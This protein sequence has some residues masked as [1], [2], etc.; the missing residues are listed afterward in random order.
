MI[1]QR[2]GK[3]TAEK[4]KPR[5]CH[6]AAGAGNMCKIVKWASIPKQEKKEQAKESGTKNVLSHSIQ[7]N[8]IFRIFFILAKYSLKVNSEYFAG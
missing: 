5:A 1:P 4:C 3:I 2:Q 6:A 7:A 8:S